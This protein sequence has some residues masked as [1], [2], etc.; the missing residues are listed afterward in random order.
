MIPSHL[1]D[2][3]GAALLSGH[4]PDIRSDRGLRRRRHVYPYLLVLPVTA[5]IATLVLYPLV[6][7]LEQSVRV[8]D[9]I[10]PTMHNFVGFANYASVLTD[11]HFQQAATNTAFYFLM[12]AVGSILFALPVALW[13]N[14]IG[15]GRTVALAMLILPWAVPGTV[16]GVLWTFIYNP[17]NGLLDGVLKALNLIPHY[18]VWLGGSTLALILVGLALLWQVMPITAVIFLAGLQG[19]PTYLYEQA[20][21]D[22]GSGFA[23]FWHITLPLLRPSLAIGLVEACTLGIGVFD[24]VYVLA[25]YAPN[26]I[27]AVIQTY[28]YAFQDLN[29]GQG[30]AAAMVVTIA[31]FVVAV[32]FLRTLYRE[33]SY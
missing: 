33:V 31:S 18:V 23:T 24:Q 19:I 5:L 21:C 15:K 26:T 17:T 7:S 3:P 2:R 20:A 13:L 25:G 1:P 32:G 6:V 29:L 30:V 14:S 11:P 12:M 28:L 9:L 22:G 27:S 16:D 8:E 4:L 10:Y